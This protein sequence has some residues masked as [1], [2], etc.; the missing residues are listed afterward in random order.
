MAKHQAKFPFERFADDAI[1]HCRT[2][3]EAE[4]V[5]SA[6]AERLRECVGWSFIRKRPRLS[7]VGM[8]IGEVATRMRSLIFWAIL[9]GR[10]DRRIGR[11]STSSI[12][13]LRFPTK[14]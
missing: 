5:R 2:E 1:V 8:M 13:V 6:I 11:G 7:I 12:S 3:K 9:F 10:E 4:E 14:R